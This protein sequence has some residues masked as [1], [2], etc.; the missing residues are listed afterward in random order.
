M[1]SIKQRVSLLRAYKGI[2]PYCNQPIASLADLEVDHIVPESLK[3]SELKP[4]LG[5]IGFPTLQIN[6]YRNWLPVH[7]YNCNLRKSGSILPDTALAMQLHFAAEKE[8]SVMAE[9]QRFD[10]ELRSRDALALLVREIELGSLSKEAAIAFLQGVKSQAQKRSE[11][12][13]LSFSV[14]LAEAIESGAIPEE[15]LSSN[16]EDEMQGDSYEIDLDL[17]EIDFANS[18]EGFLQNVLQ[19]QID[20]LETLCCKSEVSVNNGET[21]SVRYAV[22]LLDLDSL[23]RQFPCKWKLLEIAMFSEVYPNKDSEDLINKAVILKRNE[24]LIDRDS[25]E[26]LPYKFCPLCASTVLHK[27][28]HQRHDET[29]YVIRCDCGWAESF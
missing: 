14:N 27:S 24:I 2:C 26:P 9:E 5:R 21:I 29:I 28:S 19:D 11:P 18:I 25:D 3:E 23:P 13:V 22:W 16:T 12:W 7:G 8:P 6:S 4:L 15:I 1:P 17:P 20:S 10:R